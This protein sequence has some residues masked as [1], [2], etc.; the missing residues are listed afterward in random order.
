MSRDPDVVVVGAGPAGSAVAARLATLGWRVVVLDRGEFPR[1]K[2]CG[3]CLNPSAV[4]ELEKLGVLESVRQEPHTVLGGWRIACG[5]GFFDGRFT[6]GSGMAIARERLDAVLLRGAVERGAEVR[7][8]E[9]VV[10]VERGEGGGVEGVRLASGEVV[11]APL[12]VGAD[13]LRS[14]VVRRLGL[15]ARRPR[16]RKLA[17]TARVEGLRGGGPGGEL[18]VVDGVT[19]GV[20]PVGEGVANVTVVLSGASGRS[21]AGNPEGR[22]DA[23]IARLPEGDGL[24]RVGEVIATGPFDCPVRSAVV[25]GAMLVGDAAGYFDP[26]TGQGIY[27]ALRGAALAAGVAHEALG[28]GDLRA[29][30]LRPYDRARRLAF[31][32]GERLQRVIEAV[33]ARERWLARAVSLLR[34]RPEVADTLVAVTGDVL[35]VRALWSPKTLARLVG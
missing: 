31:G 5:G 9:R 35:P 14:V 32:P 25:D 1:R 12:V 15:L 34:A 30:A 13:G 6:A 21:V 17:L 8:G 27:R 16:L 3:D 23:I 33:V 11:R 10:D 2:P 7:T 26:F 28:R 19:I 29:G 24:R 22:Y 4:A 20:A 18:H